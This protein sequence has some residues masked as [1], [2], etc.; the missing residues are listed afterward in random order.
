MTDIGRGFGREAFGAD[1]ANYDAA[2]PGYPDWVFEALRGVR[3]LGPGSAV[4]EIGAGTGKATRRLL[5]LGAD[6]LVA[7]EPDPRLAA[8]LRQA[9]DAPALTVQN[10]PF[11]AVDLP[12][13]AFDLGFAATSFHW[14][15]EDAALPKIRRLLRPGAW[16]A[17]AWH[18][19]GDPERQDHFHQATVRLFEGA[20]GSPSAGA[21]GVAYALD[22]PRRLAALA[23]AG[24]EAQPPR[25]DRWEL[26]L[27]PQELV[28]LYATYS[29]VEARA[30][31]AELL[32]ALARIARDQ[33]GGRVTRN[34]ITVLYLARRR[35]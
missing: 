8:F 13:A 4:F 24:F 12:E 5:Q 26:V 33:F 27:N 20:P 11:E 34:M 14:L 1:P 35:A 9:C 28:A 17:A 2:R 32:A 3:A 25:L 23:R 7:I 6:P 30:D 31:R 10:V 19:F 22:A 15:D 18:V 21:G 29:N 16:W